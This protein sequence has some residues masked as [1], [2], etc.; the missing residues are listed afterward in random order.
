PLPFPARSGRSAADF[1]VFNIARDD[2]ESRMR[3]GPSHTPQACQP[4]LVANRQLGPQMLPFVAELA[5]GSLQPAPR[6][7]VR[8]LR[9]VEPIATSACLDMQRVKIGP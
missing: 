8:D 7:R 1:P 4:C 9:S 6:S 3:I 5:E 2:S